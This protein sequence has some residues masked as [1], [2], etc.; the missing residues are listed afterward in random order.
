[1]A[2]AAGGAQ[3]AAFDEDGDPSGADGEQASHDRDSNDRE[4]QTES[5]GSMELVDAGAAGMVPAPPPYA[6]HVE[7]YQQPEG[8]VKAGWDY[9]INGE[10]QRLGP[11][12]GAFKLSQPPIAPGDELPGRTGDNVGLSYMFNAATSDSGDRTAAVTCLGCHSTHLQ[13]KLVIGLGRANRMVRMDDVNVLGIAILNPLAI[14]D[15]IST[16]G[17]L[18]GGVIYGVMDV[19]PYLAAHRDPKTLKWTDSEVFNPDAGVEGWVDIPPWWRAAKKNGLYSNGVGRG[20][21]GHHM[22][23]MSV[24]SVKD[25]KE[26][27]VIEDHFDDVAAYLRSIEPPKYPGK[28]DADLAAQGE[29]LYFQNCATCHGTYG[30]NE[31]YPNLIIPYKDVG[32]DPSLATGHWMAPAVDWYMK[33]WYARDK[34]SWLENVEGYYAPPLDG[35]W[36]TAPFFHNGSVPTLDGVINPKKRPATW[37]SNMSADDY[38][39]ER[40]GWMDKPLD[41]DLTVDLAFGRFDTSAPG[42]SNVGHT[43]GAHLDEAEAK[44]LLEYLKTL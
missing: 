15:S 35:I 22:S 4:G 19:F 37:T 21:Q 11:N 3:V 31:S 6:I 44:A 41:L 12:L 34:R 40:V 39:L 26:A 13:G 27:A 5:A 10:Y 38:D 7:P 17:R 33:S 16:L 20:V 2:C 29:A 36:A 8:D 14:G 25:T 28:V 42:N 43:F 18:L 1:M 24:F 32:T 30:R 23:F 9:L